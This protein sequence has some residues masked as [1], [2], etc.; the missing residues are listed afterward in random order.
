MARIA[1]VFVIALLPLPA[2]AQVCMGYPDSNRVPDVVGAWS[3]W[4]EVDTYSAEMRWSFSGPGH[5]FLRA[6]QSSVDEV[7]ERIRGLTGGAVLSPSE[8]GGNICG[9]ASFGWE[10]WSP[11]GVRIRHIQVPVGLAVGFQHRPS[12]GVVLA[13]FLHGYYMAES[14]NVQGGGRDQGGVWGVEPGIGVA[15][16]SLLVR[17]SAAVE[18]QRSSDPRFR[19]ELGVLGPSR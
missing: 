4:E 18:E 15:F 16:S 11:A 7:D 19:V 9:V 14:I 12:D 13:P 1:A 17:V 6:H 3:S 2:A 8:L 5:Y 10:R